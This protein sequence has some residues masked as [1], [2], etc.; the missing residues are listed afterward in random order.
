MRL[1]YRHWSELRELVEPCKK[2]AHPLRL[3]SCEVIQDVG[4]MVEV[5]SSVIDSR[6]GNRLYL[7]YYERLLK[8]YYI[9]LEQN[10]I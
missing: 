5:H 9:C 10:L 8:V 3:S 2:I 7:P 4:K 1:T 6:S